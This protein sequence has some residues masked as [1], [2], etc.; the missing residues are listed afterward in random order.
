[1]NLIKTVTIV[2]INS[3][4]VQKIDDMYHEKMKDKATLTS[5]FG[6]NKT[7]DKKDDNEKPPM[8]QKEVQAT[9]KMVT[10]EM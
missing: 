8:Y 4:V 9:A 6:L 3:L 7:I 2:C 1:M 5:L 10:N